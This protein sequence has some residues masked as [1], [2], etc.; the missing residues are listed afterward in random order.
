MSIIY[1]ILPIISL[2]S[3]SC[4]GIEQIHL[5]LTG[6]NNQTLV[7]WTT[8]NITHNYIKYGPFINNK[9]SL[10]NISYQIESNKFNNNY[11]D[12]NGRITYIHY[13]LL[14]NLI[15]NNYYCYQ[16]HNEFNSSYIYNFRMFDYHKNNTSI[17]IFGDFDDNNNNETAKSIYSKI[18]EY[19]FIIH[20]GD[21]A[22][23]LFE[24]NGTNGDNYLNKMQF[25]NARIHYMTTPGNHE[26]YYN[27]SQQK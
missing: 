19:D 13:G 17:L 25:I 4:L 3:N 10:K 24:N 6:T 22:Y 21:I 26:R 15:P 11:N 16:I 8:L 5:S 23:D 14:N 7:T 2:L 12:K 9:C 18:G 27:F 20:N 1:F